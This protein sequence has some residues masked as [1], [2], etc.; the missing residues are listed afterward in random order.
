MLPHLFPRTEN[1]NDNILIHS[2]ELKT[3]SEW[4]KAMI[5]TYQNQIIDWALRIWSNQDLQSLDFIRFLK[6]DVLQLNNCKNIIPKLENRTIKELRLN[7]CDIFSVKDFHLENLEMLH[8]TNLSKQQKQNKLVQEILQFK[9]LKSVYLFSFKI[10][11]VSP[12]SQMTGLTVLCLNDCDIRSTEA[13][14]PLI[15]LTELFL[16]NN[17]KVDITIIQYLTKLQVLELQSCNLVSIDVLRPLTKLEVLTISTNS[18]VYIQP[19]VEMKQLDYLSASYNKILDSNVMEQHQ[20]FN[21]FYFNE[22][23]QP[24]KI[25]LSVANIL[26]SINSPII[27]LKS[28]QKQA[29]SVKSQN[30]SFRLKVS[31]NL[32]KQ[33][34]N[35]S[36][37]VARAGSLLQQMNQAVEWQ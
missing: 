15:N 29:R 14:R 9:K 17:K 12:L 23:I 30:N 8:F 25:E 4:D 34:N 21:K 19:L 3:L 37:F 10:V 27:S 33:F 31:E 35:F 32:Q 7:D 2:E 1:V 26:R 24:T 36:Q 13:L 22:E 5:K 11:D 28:I 16:D 20:N 18:L 6:I